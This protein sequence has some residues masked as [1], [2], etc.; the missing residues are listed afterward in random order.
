[1]D[2]STARNNQSGGGDLKRVLVDGCLL[3]G[4][5]G[6]YVSGKWVRGKTDFSPPTGGCTRNDYGLSCRAIKKN[7]GWS[8]RTPKRIPVYLAEP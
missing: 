8:Y 6:A 1:M 3:F 7:F 4:Y 5:F 2:V